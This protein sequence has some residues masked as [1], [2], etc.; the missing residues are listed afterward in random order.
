MG[1][2]NHGTAVRTD[3][4]MVM[5]RRPPHKIAPAITS[6]VHFTDETESGEYLKSTINGNQPDARVL[7]RYPVVQCGWSKVFVDMGYRAEYDATLGGNLITMLSQYAFNLL[8]CI[9][10]TS[11]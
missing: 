4:M 2:I 3:Q 1:K 5:P 6:E 8:F 9:Y 7:L 10:H 11:I